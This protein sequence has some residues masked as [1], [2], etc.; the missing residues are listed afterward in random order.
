VRGV[1]LIDQFDDM[2]DAATFPTIRVLSRSKD[3]LKFGFDC[4]TIDESM[5]RRQSRQTGKQGY[6]NCVKSAAPAPDFPDTFRC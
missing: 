1:W 2:A 4:L 3:Q 6:L 5:Q